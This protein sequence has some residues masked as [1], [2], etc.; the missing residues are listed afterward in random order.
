MTTTAAAAISISPPRLLAPLLSLAPDDDGPCDCGVCIVDVS[1]GLCARPHLLS[2]CP[3]PSDNDEEHVFVSEKLETI[4]RPEA[5]EHTTRFQQID[6]FQPVPGPFQSPRRRCGC[7]H[8]LAS[9]KIWLL[10]QAFWDAAAC[11]SS[12]AAVA[13]ETVAVSSPLRVLSDGRAMR[14]R[15]GRCM[16]WDGQC[17]VEHWSLMHSRHR[18]H[19]VGE[20]DTAL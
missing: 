3:N 1:D 7:R 15:R 9:T 2:L 12:V 8:K 20:L 17:A 11:P 19:S 10:V 18:Q 14:W 5:P 13:D 6:R 4:D 16:G